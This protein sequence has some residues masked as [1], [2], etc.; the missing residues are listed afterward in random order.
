MNYSSLIKYEAGVSNSLM[1]PIGEISISFERFAF[2]VI[3][4]KYQNLAV[5]ATIEYMDVISQ[6]SNFKKFYDNW[7]DDFR[8]CIDSALKEVAR[9][10]IAI[11]INDYD[12]DAVCSYCVDNDL[13]DQYIELLTQADEL[14]Q[15]I[16]GEVKEARDA[17][18]LRYENRERFYADNSE[19]ESLSDLFNNEKDA[20]LLDTANSFFHLAT[21]FV[22]DFVSEVRADKKLNNFFKSE[23]FQN[24]LKFAFFDCV[25][26]LQIVIMEALNDE[27]D[28]D[29]PS[30][31]DV[32]KAERMLNNLT[33]GLYK[34][35]DEDSIC[36]EI[37]NLDPYNED[38]YNFI[39]KKY[40]DPNGEVT[41]MATFFGEDIDDTK[42]EL[43]LEYVKGLEKT[44]KE[45]L[46]KAREKLTEYA[47]TLSLTLTEELDCV[48]LLNEIEAELDK[49]S[50]TVE[51]I[52]VS[53]VD[54]VDLVREQLPK[55]KAI[56]DS[57]PSINTVWDSV[58][59]LNDYKN[60]LREKRKEV[61]IQHF[62]PELANKYIGEIDKL[63]NDAEI[64]IELLTEGP[65]IP[66]AILCAVLSIVGLIIG[67][68]CKEDEPVKSK[69]CIRISIIAF[70]IKLLLFIII[71]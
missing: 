1:S 51:D 18:Q 68:S 9:D 65:S 55:V 35:E 50:R 25:Q 62:Q 11:G 46:D 12:D 5:E 13:F 41:K 6:Y 39:L 30:D 4:T 45:D 15:E 26:S 47:N 53:S 57:I 60:M 19:A 48:A 7:Q 27:I 52:V 31:E 43:A 29:I 32:K 10:L 20:L 17:R 14:Y 69:I 38:V 28:F 71:H 24:E 49:Q 58:D 64:H 59:K 56:M 16:N 3:F 66:L 23:K 2:S 21:D 37:I 34:P 61:E 42:E 54:D 70:C 22:G 8:S 33:S 36:R 44:T 63:F 67:L 40:G